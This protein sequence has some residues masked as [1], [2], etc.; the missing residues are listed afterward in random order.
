MADVKISALTAATVLDGT[1]VLPVVQTSTKK[2]A[3]ALVLQAAGN[4][5]AA[6]PGFSFA[7]DPDTGIYR[8]GANELGIATGGTLRA[9]VNSTG[10]TVVGSL[11]TGSGGIVGQVYTSTA[12]ISTSVAGYNNSGTN[13]TALG[14]NAGFSNTGNDMV[15]VGTVAGYGNTAVALTAVGFQTGSLNTGTY[16]TAVGWNAGR[17]NTGNESTVVGVQAGHTNTGG[18]VTAVGVNAGYQ[19][20]G[21]SLTAVG[22]GAGSGNTYASVILFGRSAV[23]AAANEMVIGSPSYAANRW[24]PGHDPDTYLDFATADTVKHYAGGVK[25]L[26][27]N[28]TGGAPFLGFFGTAAVAKPTGVAV[29]A[30]GIHAALVTLGLIAA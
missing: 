15:T 8:I 16:L 2:A 22:H 20:T 11:V 5:S 18:N 12:A 10:L 29:T 26:E 17:S 3:V 23:A 28:E 1:E 24:I 21:A 7:S 13:V 6:A 4:G 19:N 9:T 25:V 14:N 27:L 30:G